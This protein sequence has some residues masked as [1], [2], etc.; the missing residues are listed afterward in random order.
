MNVSDGTGHHEEGLQVLDFAQEGSARI[1]ETLVIRVECLC[2]CGRRHIESLK[3]LIKRLIVMASKA[4]MCFNPKNETVRK[5]GDETVRRA[6][7]TTRV[8]Y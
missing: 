3:D 7:Q 2:C 8:L 6:M 1:D 5:E 4:T